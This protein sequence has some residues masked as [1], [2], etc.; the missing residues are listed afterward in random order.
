[1]SPAR[2]P[3]AA[4]TDMRTCLDFNRDSIISPVK[5]SCCDYYQNKT[6]NVLIS[7]TWNDKYEKSTYVSVLVQHSRE[8]VQTGTHKEVME[9]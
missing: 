8:P 1:M 4:N 2:A 3:A 5:I 9:M 6:K 7:K